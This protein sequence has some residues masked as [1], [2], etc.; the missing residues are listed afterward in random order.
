MG[1]RVKTR[2]IRRE[3]ELFAEQIG[4]SADE[5]DFEI[6]SYELVGPENG[7]YYAE[8][9]IELTLKTPGII[10]VF[11]C[12]VEVDDTERTSRAY[13][14]VLPTFRMEVREEQ[15]RDGKCELDEEQEEELLKETQKLLLR[16][17]V[18]Y[19]HLPSEK[20]VE[21]WQEAVFTVYVHKRPYKF[22]VAEG[23]PPKDPFRR[24]IYYIPLI[25]TAGKV[26]NERTGRIDFKD[27]G[28]S[29]RAVKEGEKIV[30]V[31]FIPGEY[32]IRVTGELIPFNELDP[33]PFKVDEETVEVKK[34]EKKRRI[35]YELYAKKDGYVSIEDGVLKVSEYVKEKRVDYSTGSIVFDDASVDIEISGEGDKTF[36]DAVKDGFELISPGKKVLIKGNVGRKAVIEGGE[37]IIEGLVAKDAVIKGEICKVTRIT[38]ARIIAHEAVYVERALSSEIEAPRVFAETLSG[39]RVYA[40]RVVALKVIRH[41]HIYAYDFIAVERAEDFNHL[42]LDGSEVSIVRRRWQDKEHKKKLLEKE[43]EVELHEL[44]KL[45]RRMEATINLAVNYLKPVLKEKADKIK[46][47]ITT[48]LHNGDFDRLK[49]LIERFPSHVKASLETAIS[50]KKKQKEIEKRIAE[51][52]GR[53]QK[54][55]EEISAAKDKPGVVCVFDRL[56]SDNLVRIKRLKRYFTELVKGPV[57]F[58]DENGVLNSTSD[59]EQIAS[60][61]RGRVDED[62]LASVRDY[63]LEKG[64]R[65]YVTKLKL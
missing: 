61:M 12:I 28:Y 30:R 48:L 49:T 14:K 59:V 41:S 1:E 40:E 60:V 63:L 24:E 11:D 36:I 21:G 33:L 26:V 45:K 62:Y 57:V 16:E 35:V 3:L 10:R 58:Y 43:K 42:I 25:T 4:C 20:M 65:V 5:I 39:S 9:E 18:I 19:G 34:E 55:D 32:G 37:V 13:L 22:V 52:E 15:F 38:D 44:E 64:L 53:I 56:V 46:A 31:E 47:L 2:D 54:L 29:D 27:R 8:V 51:L 7:K 23:K 17:G 50:L 6:I